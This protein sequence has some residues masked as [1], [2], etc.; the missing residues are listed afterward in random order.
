MPN[1]RNIN[2]VKMPEKQ[3]ANELLAS[4]IAAGDLS[5]VDDYS[6]LSAVRQ[7]ADTVVVGWAGSSEDG[8]YQAA[9]LALLEETASVS[10][11]WG[12][13]ESVSVSQA[14][15]VNAVSAAALDYDSVHQESLLHPA[16]VTAPVALAMDADVK[17]SG[18]QIVAAHIIGAEV[19]CRISLATPRQSNW[20][21]ASIYGVFGATATA[22]VLLNLNVEQTLNALGLA[23]AQTSGTKQAIIERAL[24]KRYQTAFAARAGVLSAVLAKRGVTAAHQF[25]DGTAGLFSLYETGTPE[26]VV[27]GLANVFCFQNITIKR[28]PTCLCTHVLIEAMCLLMARY[29]FNKDDVATVKI[30]ITPYMNRI[31]GG[32]YEPKSNPQVAAQFSAK[33]ATARALF[34]GGVTLSDIGPEQALDPEIISF[35]QAIELTLYDNIDGHVAPCDISVELKNGQAFSEHVSE[36]PNAAVGSD[37][38]SALGAKANDCLTR[39]V[40]PM[41]SHVAQRVFERLMNMRQAHS[42]DDLF[43]ES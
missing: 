14:V 29:G 4:F 26:K 5:A 41:S 12:R 36:V 35:A 17:A 42:L 23:L 22:A 40:L 2:A 13:A 10:R 15:F 27:A 38:L 20:F 24:A 16:A 37:A 1:H 6:W 21:P 9:D 28:Y 25:L 18:E 3:D 7:I 30:R 11:L 34:S 31:I 32:D 19:M 43:D 8:A 39:G 33:Y